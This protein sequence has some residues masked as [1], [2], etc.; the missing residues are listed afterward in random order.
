MDV[1]P[2]EQSL[3]TPSSVSQDGQQDNHDV[4]DAIITKN[5]DLLQ[6]KVYFKKRY[7]TKS[8]QI[9]IKSFIKNAFQN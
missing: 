2:H 9:G 4:L 1:T 6:S 7:H 8:D 5:D 3:R